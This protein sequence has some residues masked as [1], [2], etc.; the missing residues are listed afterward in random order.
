M[1]W[2]HAI[3][4]FSHFL[5]IERGLSQNTI[6]NYTFDIR[7]L[8]AYLDIHD[9]SMSPLDI[10]S[11]TIRQFVYDTAKTISAR[12]QSR[13]IS[14]IR[15]FFDYLVFEDYRKSNPMDHY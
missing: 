15:N 12:S 1:K 4:D 8:I 5:K 6:D 10:D 11:D 7:K 3:Q 9:I 14:G 2:N 13:M